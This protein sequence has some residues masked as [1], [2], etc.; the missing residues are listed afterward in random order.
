LEGQQQQAEQVQK[1]LDDFKTEIEN[2]SACM[3]DN[4]KSQVRR[5]TMSDIF[6]Y[7]LVKNKTENV[8]FCYHL[9]N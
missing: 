2:R 1:T 9:V 8:R 4:M 6:V 3:Y 7:T 5:Y